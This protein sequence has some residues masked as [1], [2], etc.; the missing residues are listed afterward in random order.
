MDRL[1]KNL[2][3]LGMRRGDLILL[4]ALLS[5]SVILWIIFAVNQPKPE[6]VSVRVDGMEITRLPL[7]IDR[8]YRI[9]E[10]NTIEISGGSVRMTEATCPD[11]ICVK[12]GP[13]S[14]GGHSIVCAPHKVV[15][16]I[17]SGNNDKSYDAVTN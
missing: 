10:G 1:R 15:I 17:T 5:F 16:L 3:Q 4:T 8:V 11:Q 12:T 2:R 14:H 6:Y 9:S 7:N 13:I